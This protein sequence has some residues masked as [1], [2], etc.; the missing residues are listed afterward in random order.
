MTWTRVALGKVKEPIF[1]V[2][3]KD[4]DTEYKG[5]LYTEKSGKS[6]DVIYEGLAMSP[7]VIK[8]KVLR[9]KKGFTSKALSRFDF[10]VLKSDMRS[11]RNAGA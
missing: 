6:F 10:S 9:H 7:F 4:G 1:R 2:V 3:T 11:A 5:I 8:D